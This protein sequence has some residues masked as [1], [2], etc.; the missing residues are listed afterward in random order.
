MLNDSVLSNARPK[1]LLHQIGGSQWVQEKRIMKDAIVAL[2]VSYK[3][4]LPYLVETLSDETEIKLLENNLDE[5][6]KNILQKIWEFRTAREQE[7][8]EFGDYVEELLSNPFLPLEI[9]Q[10]GIQWL[11][12]KIRIEQ[13]QKTESEAAKIIADYAFKIFQDQPGKKDFYLAGPTAKVR[14]K[15]YVFES[16]PMKVPGQGTGSD[17]L[18]QV[19]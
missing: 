12:S 17:K 7:D 1:R 5:G 18:S 19:A 3:E 4:S 2:I 14:V 6:Q 8:D 15:I 10:H 9:Q 13:Y 11:R 16:T